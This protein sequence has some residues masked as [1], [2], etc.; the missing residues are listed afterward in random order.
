[1][2][3][4]Y[5]LCHPTVIYFDNLL[6]SLSKDKFISMIKFYEII[7]KEMFNLNK[8]KILQY[9]IDFMIVRKNAQLDLLNYNFQVTSAP[10][11]KQP[12]TAVTKFQLPDSTQ[13]QNERRAMRLMD[14]SYN[15]IIR[16]DPI[17]LQAGSSFVTNHRDVISC[18]MSTRKQMRSFERRPFDNN[19]LRGRRIARRL[20][21]SPEDEK[22]QAECM[23]SR[24]SLTPQSETTTPLQQMAM[25][26]S[27]TPIIVESDTPPP[28]VPS[29]PP[30]PPQH[31]FAKTVQQLPPATLIK[32]SRL[33]QPIVNGSGRDERD[34]KKP[35]H[36][37]N[38]NVP[39]TEAAMRQSMK[40]H[41]ERSSE[42]NSCDPLQ[43]GQISIQE[44][45]TLS[46]NGTEIIPT[47]ILKNTIMN[48]RPSV[49]QDRVQPVMIVNNSS[50]V[51]FKTG[52]KFVPRGFSHDDS[53]KPSLPG[54]KAQKRRQSCHER[55]MMP[56]DNEEKSIE[57]SVIGQNYM[58]FLN[59]YENE[60]SKKKQQETQLQRQQ[61]NRPYPHTI[62]EQPKRVR[63][64]MDV[65][66]DETLRNQ[67]GPPPQPHFQYPP[68][69]SQHM[70]NQQR[71]IHFQHQQG[72]DL[73]SPLK[74]QPPPINYQYY[75]H[76]FER[77]L[78][79]RGYDHR[80]ENQQEPNRPLEL[81][82]HVPPERYHQNEQQR[83][84]YP[85][86]FTLKQIRPSQEKPTRLQPRMIM[87]ID[88][89][90]AAMMA[91]YRQLQSLH[92][93]PSSLTSQQYAEHL[94]H[95][96]HLK[97]MQPSAFTAYQRNVQPLEGQQRAPQDYY[98]N[99]QELH[100]QQMKR[101]SPVQY[102]ISSSS[103]R[104]DSP[105]SYEEQSLQRKLKS[106]MKSSKYIEPNQLTKPFYNPA[107][108]TY[109]SEP[110][111]LTKNKTTPSEPELPPQIAPTAFHPPENQR[112]RS[113]V[114]RNLMENATNAKHYQWFVAQA[115]A[116]AH[117]QNL[118]IHNQP[119]RPIPR[120]PVPAFIEPKANGSSH[121]PMTVT[122]QEQPTEFLRS[123]YANQKNF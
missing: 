3:S 34:E 23:R 114:G 6:P 54:P 119:Q 122:F 39:T 22:L 5:S 74:P 102:Q 103:S 116:N 81:V 1:M 57:N 112:Q 63:F 11:L 41:Y 77:E 2:F 123:Y 26:R 89:Q 12:P 52:N 76:Q 17:Y 64:S 18:R 93:D 55:I 48:C 7:I 4:F 97:H 104:E 16:S 75:Q 101:S 92:R 30:S 86:N 28:S 95:L 60:I 96:D 88:S 31:K 46:Q 8:T 73:R 85:N 47:S 87:S 51:D 105:N 24:F 15:F 109:Y 66:A 111:A 61:Q 19:I 70:E 49:E 13:N 45:Q 100:G 83:V 40:K 32:P 113:P 84:H 42:P 117:A 25:M 115:Q 98:T 59:F 37:E 108:S 56:A 106:K 118:A 110:F 65:D 38:S 94:K 72:S 107:H 9:L 69:Q 33:D 67:H 78:R 53:I 120:P 14:T 44:I 80:I 68:T 21:R 82:S 36:G 62:H 90:Q 29:E 99:T 27:L 71:I 20:V 10:N 79:E 121:H 58:E 43:N 50:Q 91:A 35:T